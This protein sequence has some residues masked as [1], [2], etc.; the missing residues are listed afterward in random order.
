[1]SS[2]LSFIDSELEEELVR[3]A[4]LQDHLSRLT[5]RTVDSVARFIIS[6]RWGETLHSYRLFANCVIII[7]RY[8]IQ[9]LNPLA[10]LLKIV[11]SD[12]GS[13]LTHF[14]KQ[15]LTDLFAAVY[16]MRDSS[17]WNPHFLLVQRLVVRGLYHIGDVIR[18]LRAL[19]VRTP[20]DHDY[21]VVVCAIFAP[22][23]EQHAPDIFVSFTEAF[24]R[25]N[26]LLKNPDSVYLRALFQ[27]WACLRVNNYQLLKE[28]IEFGHPA[29]SVGH[30]IRQDDIQMLRKGMVSSGQKLALSFVEFCPVLPRDPTLLEYA[31]FYG[32]LSC[33]KFLLAEGGGTDLLERTVERRL[34]EKMAIAGGNVEIVNIL[35]SLGMTFSECITT[36]VLFFRTDLFTWLVHNKCGDVLGRSARLASVCSASAAAGNIRTLLFCIDQRCEVNGKLKDRLPPLHCAID[37]CRFTAARLLLAHPL[38]KVNHKAGNYETPL[39]IA[40][41]HGLTYIVELM[42]QRNDVDPNARDREGFTPLHQACEGNH[43]ETVKLLLQ[44]RGIDTNPR[45][46]QMKMTPL[47]VAAERGFP[48]VLQVLLAYTGPSKP[49]ELNA[50]DKRDATPLIIVAEIGNESCAKILLDYPGVELNAQ[51]GDGKS[52]LHCAAEHGGGE[53]LTMLLA[54]KGL[55][56]NVK[57]RQGETAMHYCVRGSDHKPDIEV[58]KALLK[59]KGID[60]GVR[61]V[62]LCFRELSFCELAKVCFVETRHPWKWPKTWDSLM[63]WSY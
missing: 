30:A 12:H 4:E 40:A 59:V 16:H 49:V 3:V 21:M 56:V 11:F 19:V 23:L 14:S 63:L 13:P 17:Y 51:D 39:A 32:S 5:P 33:F 1:M 42:L 34:I 10:D 37:C 36:A 2:S 20:I 57:D 28:H 58:V 60:I 43:V 50:R 38:V 22:E 62:R 6:A 27:T 18:H 9:V 24:Q 52:A 26:P 25:T 29:G 53:V 48:D 7:L 31:A 47:H 35:V 46:S 15:F 55:N 44:F 41:R 54:M 8:L 45:D 61:N